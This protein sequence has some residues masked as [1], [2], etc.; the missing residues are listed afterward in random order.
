MKPQFSLTCILGSS[1]LFSQLASGISVASEP[2]VFLTT[3][4]EVQEYTNGIAENIRKTAEAILSIPHD[5][6]TFENTL[7]PWNRL[8]TQLTKDFN[9]LDVL[10]KLDSPSITIASQVSADLQD[11]LLEV[12]Q[13][14]DLC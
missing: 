4:K 10:G 5:Q 9:T 3:D 1:I 11:Y 2:Q 13:N 7:R 6:Q 12:T 14:L 8:A